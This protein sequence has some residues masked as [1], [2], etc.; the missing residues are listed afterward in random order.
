V[1]FG[2]NHWPDNL[3]FLHIKGHIPDPAFD[4]IG[5]SR[6]FNKCHIFIFLYN[7]LSVYDFFWKD[8]MYKRIHLDQE[9][10]QG[11]SQ[12]TPVPR[13]LKTEESNNIG[14]HTGETNAIL[15]MQQTRGNAYVRRYLKQAKPNHGSQS[16]I[17]R[18]P[19]K[20][21]ADSQSPATAA[22]PVIYLRAKMNGDDIR[23]ASKRPGHEGQIEGSSLSFVATAPSQGSQTD[24]DGKGTGKPRVKSLT[25]TKHIDETTPIFFNASMKGNLIDFHFELVKKDGD[26]ETVSMTYDFNEAVVSQQI[27]QDMEILT[28]FL[29]NQ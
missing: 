18:A 1:C 17:R 24:N 5:I 10:L 8:A 15:R 22:A 21:G 26:Q 2:V 6:A 25:F 16:L 23:G 19:D 14:A 4:A 7:N 20:T 12:T 28:I 3:N 11:R 27:S 13:D 29:N 9:K